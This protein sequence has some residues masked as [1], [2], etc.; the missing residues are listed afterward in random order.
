MKKCS[1]CGKVY[2]DD[3]VNC[4]VDN[5][6]LMVCN[7]EPESNRKPRSAKSVLIFI[8]V[9]V[10]V[11]SIALFLYIVG[12]GGA[13]RRS[14]MIF[15]QNSLKQAQMELDETGKVEAFGS[16]KPFLFTNQVV[17][18][19]NVYQG[20]VAIR[21]NRFEDEGFLVMSTNEVFIWID[22]KHGSK[23]I[24]ASNYMPNLFPERF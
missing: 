3:R 14:G 21:I 16:A 12:Y 23:I 9:A 11:I 22:K 19:G 20:S 10:T 5:A 1:R 6:P 17:V 24:P 7:Q 8:S 13:L 2:P 15:A 4:A 18:D